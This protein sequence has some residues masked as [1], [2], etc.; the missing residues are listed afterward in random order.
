MI[1]RA[2]AV[3]LGYLAMREQDWR[4]ALREFRLECAL[5]GNPADAWMRM[6]EA[7]ER[8]GDARRAA[9]CYARELQ[10]H[11]GNQAAWQALKR[12]GGS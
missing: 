9:A 1:L 7:W 12:L 10:V 8:L 2:K 11:A 4:R 5:G 3:R 6:G